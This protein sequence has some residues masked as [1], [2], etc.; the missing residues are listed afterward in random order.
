VRL[1]RGHRDE[2]VAHAREESPNECC[3]YLPLKDGSVDRVERAESKRRSPYG[4]QP[5]V[6]L[7]L[8]PGPRELAPRDLR[9]R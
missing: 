9:P 4:Y 6:D 5:Q 7:V 8:S 2:L 3:G 1:S